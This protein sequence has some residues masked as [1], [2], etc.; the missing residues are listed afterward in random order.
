M[1][2]LEEL[3]AP[4]QKT[5]TQELKNHYAPQALIRP[6]NPVLVLKQENGK[7]A[8][9][10][11]LWGLLAEWS[12]DPI[13]SPR[14]FNAR[15]ETISSKPTF[16]TAWRHRR[17][18]LP[19]SGFY[20]KGNR[21][22]RID[23]KPFWLAGLWNRWL[24]PDGSEIESCTVIT[25]KSNSL[26]KPLHTRMPVVIEEKHEQK[27]LKQGNGMDLKALE[28]LLT[29]W[30]PKDWLIEPVFRAIKVDKQMNLF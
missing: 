5:L 23:S 7:I 15:A 21:I 3:P 9:S 28:P 20:E 19:A 1:T 8:S 29:G 24:G 13:N 12:K 10:L 14:P 22:K 17:C 26:I 27:W 6:S 18:L 25:T 4:L 16:R 2:K 30:S 11:M